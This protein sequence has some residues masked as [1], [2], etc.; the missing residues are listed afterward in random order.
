MDDCLGELLARFIFQCVWA[1]TVVQIGNHITRHQDFIIRRVVQLQSLFR[2]PRGVHIISEDDHT[3]PETDIKTC[4]QF[5]S[6]PFILSPLIIVGMLL[7]L[8]AQRSWGETTIRLIP[9]LTA[10]NSPFC[11]LLWI[12][13]AVS[14][15]RKAKDR[16]GHVRPATEPSRETKVEVGQGDVAATT[17]AINRSMPEQ[18][19]LRWEHYELALPFY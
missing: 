19:P 2:L 11:I 4:A 16:R 14:T 17:L 15:R 1:L 12:I 18:Q 7:V 13:L 10:V 5:L 8:L 6:F 9:V 3:I